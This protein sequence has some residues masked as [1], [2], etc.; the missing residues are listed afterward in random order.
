LEQKWQGLPVAAQDPKSAAGERW[1]ALIDLLK[2]EL[3]AQDM[4]DFALSCESMPVSP[5]DRSDFTNRL[6]AAVALLAAESDDRDCLVSLLS[7]RCPARIGWADVES[8][9]AATPRKT[10]DP[11]LILRDAYEKSDVP[12][13]RHEIASAVRRAFF[14]SG[15][16]YSPGAR[17]EQDDRSFVL[18]AMEWYMANK[19]R[20]AINP[21]YGSNK[22]GHS[23]E[24]HPLFVLKP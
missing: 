18:A 19:A 3:S 20:L 9:V 8:V 11:I 5:N 15:I 24:D 14:G 17:S 4:R 23:Y 6:L 2:K 21:Q 12:E 7:R 10:P 1:R 22:I 16:K 13:V